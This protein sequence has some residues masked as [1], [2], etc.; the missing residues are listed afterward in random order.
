MMVATLA[1]VPTHAMHALATQ[2]SKRPAI[3]VS[4][5]DPMPGQTF[6]VSSSIGPRIIRPVQL[7]LFTDSGWTKLTRS[8]TNSRGAARLAWRTQEAT[9]RVRIFAPRVRRGGTVLPRRA[10]RAATITTRS[11]SPVPTATQQPTPMPTHGPFPVARPQSATFT[12]KRDAQDQVGVVIVTSESTPGR[13]AA[14]Q[15]RAPGGSWRTVASRPLPGGTLTEL[16][17]LVPVSQIR[18]EQLRVWLAAFGDLEA[19]E[20]EKLVPPDVVAH[21]QRSNGAHKLS[22]TTTGEVHRVR[23]FLDGDILAEDNAAPWNVSGEL[24]GG[25]HDVVV[26]AF[27]PLESVLSTS[28]EIE[29]EP[30]TA[31]THAG[32][33]EGFQLET[34]Q[35]GFDL[36]TSAATAGADLVFVAEK[37]GV[38]QA[39]SGDGQGGWEQPGQVLDLQDLVFDGLDAGLTGLAVDPDFAENGFVYLGYAFEEG[40]GHSGWK[41]QQVARYQWDGRQ[42]LPESRH[43]VL[44]SVTGDACHDPANVRTPD[45]LPL[46]SGFHTV[47]DLGFDAAGDLLV[48]LGDGALYTSANAISART[49]TMRVQDPEVLVGKLLRV[50]AET[51]KGVSSNPLYTGDGSSNSSRVL[52]QGFRNP[53]RFTVD[54]DHVIVGD[55]GEATFEEINVVHLEQPAGK[56]AN[57]GWPCMEGNVETPLEGIDDPDSPWHLCRE[58]REDNPELPAYQYAHTVDGGSVTAGLIL[59]NPTYPETVHGQLLYGDY[60]QDR[61]HTL[62]IP[63]GEEASAGQPIADSTAAGG[64][65]KIFAGPNGW[66]WTV[67]IFG[68]ALQQLTYSADRTGGRCATGEF[69]RGFHDLDG[70]DSTFDDES[71]AYGDTILPTTV[72]AP[73]ECVGDI[74]LE[75]TKGSPWAT[76]AEPDLRAHPGDRFGVSWRG[77]VDLEGG[78]Y[79]FR[80]RASEWIRLRVDGALLHDS[81]A[82]DDEGWQHDVVL[83]PGL[84]T[85]S[86]EYLHGDVEEASASVTWKIVG[87]PPVVSLVAPS[88]GTVTDGAFGWEVSVSDADGDP[89]ADLVA[90]TRVVANLLHYN[91]GSLHVHP[92]QQ[93]AGQQTGTMVVH[94][95]HAPGSGVIRL[96][97]VTTDT[98]GAR[99]RSA[100]VYICFPGGNVGPCAD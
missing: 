23:F 1:T 90:N 50:D 9:V 30:S 29:S 66:A 56:P 16:T 63:Y 53:F 51:G 94:D 26:R 98:S 6:F 4:M 12:V 13:D 39:I 7:Q 47:G 8:T 32:M 77:Q 36:P 40:T 65:V 74:N 46:L 28:L 85:V 38:V 99:S 10:S 2:V 52:A 24:A 88:N 21:V 89:T 54:G 92:Y 68:G 91:A 73:T 49:L 96:R 83:Q 61:L 71:P 64:P 31:Q 70:P 62:S 44:G 3:V 80:A 5:S 100:P 97:A 11:A 37:R 18:G 19:Y 69:G 41:S 55:V 35:S 87:Q 60:A 93:V 45:C 14:L 78:T 15:A 20:T 81:F 59:D 43:V 86:V 84:H 76:E 27:G 57:Y 75:P 34:V 95:V 48:A 58:I 67:S 72:I 17:S 22:A 42:L 79:R 33:A 25:R 82:A